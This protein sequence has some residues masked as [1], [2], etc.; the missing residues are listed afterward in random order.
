[1][2]RLILTCRLDTISDVLW[3]SFCSIEFISLG[4]VL[5]IFRPFDHQLPVHEQVIS[6]LQMTV[7]LPVGLIAQLVVRTLLR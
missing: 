1:M 6:E 5:A 3:N 7:Q 4:L 2:N